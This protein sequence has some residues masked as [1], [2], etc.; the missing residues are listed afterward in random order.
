MGAK[1]TIARVSN[2]EY[3]EPFQKEIFQ[4]LGVDTLISPQILAAQEIERLLRRGSFTDVFEFEKGK[5]SVAGF[6]T[7]L[8]CPL[9]NKTTDEIDAVKR[10]HHHGGTE[11]Q[12]FTFSK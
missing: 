1:K 11:A 5:I 9:I 3:L 8:S 7:H 6:K 12:R 2:P 10:P 4:K